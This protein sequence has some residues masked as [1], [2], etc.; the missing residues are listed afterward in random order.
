MK[1]IKLSQA[2]LDAFGLHEVHGVIDT[3]IYACDAKSPAEISNIAI[4]TVVVLS[5]IP[6]LKLEYNSHSFRTYMCG[7]E[8][9][10]GEIVLKREPCKCVIIYF[11]LSA[12]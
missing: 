7:N 9:L 10:H 1:T 5:V 4:L 3:A 2:S 11:C 8:S 6:R 12:V